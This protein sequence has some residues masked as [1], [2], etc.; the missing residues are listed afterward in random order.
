MWHICFINLINSLFLPVR[1]G[2]RGGSNNQWRCPPPGQAYRSSRTLTIIVIT[3]YLPT[4]NGLVGSV[5]DPDPVGSKKRQF[6]FKKISATRM[7]TK[8]CAEY[9]LVTVNFTALLQGQKF[10]R[11][12]R[13]LKSLTEKLGRI[14][15]RIRIRNF[16]K[17]R[18]RIPK[19]SFR[20]HP[21]P[22]SR[23][24]FSLREY[25]TY[26]LNIKCS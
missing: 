2:L 1:E 12:G 16:L 26:L 18:I 8:K 11:Y 25:N 13:L 9:P 7:V 10:H 19:K 5:V 17:S 20:I 21:T 4:H 24:E 15:N 23:I 22:S 6:I 3:M 14:R